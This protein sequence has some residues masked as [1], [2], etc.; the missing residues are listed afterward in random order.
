MFGGRQ[1][2]DHSEE[3]LDSSGLVRLASANREDTPLAGKGECHTVCQKSSCIFDGNR[4]VIRG[5]VTWEDFCWSGVGIKN[6][7][8]VFAPSKPPANAVAV[9]TS[10]FKYRCW[11]WQT[12]NYV[13]HFRPKFSPEAGGFDNPI[14][15]RVT[16]F[17]SKVCG[18]IW[19]RILCAD[20]SQRIGSKCLTGNERLSRD[21][22]G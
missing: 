10:K 19:R 7:L 18:G 5:I 2:N 1:E 4:R 3:A 15:Y 14:L 17:A 16:T 20:K 8:G 12:R 11:N 21:L 13:A 6:G 9:L 22:P